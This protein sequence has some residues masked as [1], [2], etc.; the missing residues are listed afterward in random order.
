MTGVNR[1]KI[2]FMTKTR[3]IQIGS[4][5]VTKPHFSINYSA[6]FGGVNWMQIAILSA[7]K[8]VEDIRL[9]IFDS[10]VDKLVLDRMYNEINFY[11]FELHENNPVGYL[12]YHVGQLANIYTH[13]HFSFIE[14][15][16]RSTLVYYF[17]TIAKIANIYN[18]S[19]V[20]KLKELYIQL[21][22]NELFG[23]VF[24]REKLDHFQFNRNLN[25]LY[26]II[27]N[28]IPQRECFE[29]PETLTI[30]EFSQFLS[31][32]KID[33]YCN[34]LNYM[35]HVKLIKNIEIEKLMFMFLI[36]QNLYKYNEK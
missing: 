16:S 12:C 1:E 23:K 28:I 4:V 34:I 20:D 24:S 2:N 3:S 27:F 10:R 8:N 25:Y 19:K 29:M 33:E 31:T 6:E 17:S 26:N 32:L 5:R 9:Q 21:T 15:I 18:N 36:N 14:G 11:L 35:I 13:I 30:P 22:I 7:E